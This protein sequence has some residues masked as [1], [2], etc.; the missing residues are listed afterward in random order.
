MIQARI[1]KW[2][3][4]LAIHIPKPFALEIGLEQNSL[5]V[6]SILDDKLVLEPVRP[7]YS[8]EELLEYVTPHNLHR[9]IETGPA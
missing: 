2:N 1:Q 4:S 9:E 5:V 8:L 7:L 6:V 3:D